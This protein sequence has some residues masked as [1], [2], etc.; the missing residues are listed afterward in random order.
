M[1]DTKTTEA[2]KAEA[3]A[4]EAPKLAYKYNG[5]TIELDLSRPENL[6]RVKTLAELGSFAEGKTAELRTKEQE[7]AAERARLAADAQVGREFSEFVRQNGTA[8]R[9][10]GTIYQGIREGTLDP[11]QV[12]AA[13][14]AVKSG[15]V[16]AVVAQ[17]SAAADAGDPEARALLRQ[18]A[19]E[20]QAVKSKVEG[21][22]TAQSQRDRDAEIQAA[23][24]G[25]DFLRGR[26]AGQQFVSRR[27]R[28]L[29]AS[30][31]TASLA[32]TQATQ[33]YKD[34]LS[35]SATQERDRLRGQKELAT[36][37]PT[38][39]PRISEMTQ[40][41]IDPKAPKAVQ[42][43]QRRARLRD[44]FGAFRARFGEAVEG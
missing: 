25:I 34:V 15:D 40:R 11:S 26:E 38:G 24:S 32:A 44:A 5:K 43:E 14:S 18:V 13:L 20:L 36:A 10:L 33:E 21:V 28:E 23:V 6:E 1:S 35:E 27:T 41:T 22:E 12:Q 17:A 8:G 3:K 30:G 42:T 39:L 16:A 2:A 31:L 37:K 9:V 29:V 7:L 4:P 19:S